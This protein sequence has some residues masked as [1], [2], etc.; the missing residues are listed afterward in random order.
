MTTP[1]APEGEREER[2]WYMSQGSRLASRKFWLVALTGLWVIA[3]GTV[4]SLDWRFIVEQWR[5]IV[6]AYL[7]V[8]GVADIVGRWTNSRGWS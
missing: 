8:E 7:G 4:G 1:V 3:L 6:I 5:Y 2:R